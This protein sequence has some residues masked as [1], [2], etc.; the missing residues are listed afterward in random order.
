MAVL[1]EATINTPPLINPIPWHRRPWLFAVTDTAGLTD[2][3]GKDGRRQ[4]AK[5]PRGNKQ[6]LLPPVQTRR[7]TIDNDKLVKA[8]GLSLIDLISGEP[9]VDLHTRRGPDQG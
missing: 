6:G 5:R 7:D 9:P 3:R 1:L 8:V 4:R 2:L